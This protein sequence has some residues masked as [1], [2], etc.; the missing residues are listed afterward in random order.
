MKLIYLSADELNQALVKS[1][2]VR[3]GIPVECRC[4]APDDLGTGPCGVLIDADHSPLGSIDGILDQMIDG[5]GVVTLFVHGYGAWA[6]ELAN[7]GVSV[8]SRLQGR[9]LSTLASEV[10]SFEL[11]SARETSEAL[12]WIQLA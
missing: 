8:F 6:D 4:D 9:V 5:G 2:S 3:K 10:K 1:W 11:V 7:L 12:T